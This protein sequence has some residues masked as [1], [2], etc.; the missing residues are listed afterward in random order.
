MDR[1]QRLASNL[2]VVIGERS[3]GLGEK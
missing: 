2:Q 3:L 1:E